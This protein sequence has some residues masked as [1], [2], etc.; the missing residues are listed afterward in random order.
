MWPGGR[1]RIGPEYRVAR[2]FRVTL[3]GH[4]VEYK[5]L[6]ITHRRH[7]EYVG[8]LLGDPELWILSSDNGDGTHLYRMRVR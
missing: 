3:D 4:M 1:F 6:E 8:P 7:I 5:F 2:Y